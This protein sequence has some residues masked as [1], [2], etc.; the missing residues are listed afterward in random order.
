MF[1]DTAN[2]ENARSLRALELRALRLERIARATTDDKERG[3]LEAE[4][5]RLTA[6]C[7][8]AM[9]RAAARILERRARDAFKT[10]RYWALFTV[11]GIIAAFAAADY[12]K[13]ERDRVT[14]LKDCQAAVAA[15]AE[16]ACDSVRSGKAT[17]AAQD[18]AAKKAKAEEQALATA[19]ETFR[20]ETG[21]TLDRVEA[22]SRVLLAAPGLAGAGDEARAAVVAACVQLSGG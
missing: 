8:L 20:K 16:D 4:A 17:Q 3:R 7:R 18:T 21:T 22:C 2:E 12:S 14:L 10:S 15:G 11:L 6:A 1:E 19:R 9:T 5:A 13:G